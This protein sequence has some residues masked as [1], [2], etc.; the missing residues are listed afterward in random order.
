[1]AGARPSSFKKG[2]GF[3]D[4]VDVIITG[5]KFTDE[6]NGQPF[7]AGKIKG[8]DGK[9]MDKPHTLNCL[10]SVRVEGADEDTTTTLKVAKNFADWEVSED[11]LTVTP[12]GEATLAAGTQ[13]FKLIDSLCQ[14]GFDDTQLSDDAINYEPI[15]GQ[16][17]RFVQ[18]VDEERT[19]KYG[20]KIDK[21]TKKGYDRKDLVVDQYYGAAELPSAKPAKKGTAVKAAAKPAAASKKPAA[22]AVVDIDALSVD[23]LVAVI[24]EAGGSIQKSKL[25]MKVLTKL[26]KDP[27]REDVRKRD[28]P[29][30]RA[31]RYFGNRDKWRDTH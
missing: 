16:R 22:P 20:Q 15:I 8:N 10:L 28:M 31:R 9:P 19:K 26:M 2:G 21:K 4:G 29:S 18:R 17:V 5:Y 6:F 12:V 23:T 25:S 30:W 1:M 13:F 27:N 14:A 7:V 11:G 3:L 24:Q